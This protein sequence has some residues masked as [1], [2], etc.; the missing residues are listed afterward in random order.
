[1]FFCALNNTMVSISAREIRYFQGTWCPPCSGPCA[2]VTRGLGSKG[3][4]SRW[5]NRF[6]L[7]SRDS[8]FSLRFRVRDIN[9]WYE[10]SFFAGDLCRQSDR[11]DFT[12]NWKLNI[13]GKELHKYI[14]KYIF[15][16]WHGVIKVIMNA[17]EKKK[18]WR[19]RK[20]EENEKKLRWKMTVGIRW[21][22]E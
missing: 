20:L 17:I 3:N 19:T 15:N 21:P 22:R 12:F 9:K 11:S 16:A 13:P 4:L 14:R 1:M 6:Y 2:D 8:C 5:G 7:I 10:R 18:K